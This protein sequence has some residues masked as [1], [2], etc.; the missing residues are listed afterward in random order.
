MNSP[1]LELRVTQTALQVP[2]PCQS[3]ASAPTPDSIAEIKVAQLDLLLG[4]NEVD[5]ERV[6]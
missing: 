2:P 3:T 1:A 6:S 4:G 5:V